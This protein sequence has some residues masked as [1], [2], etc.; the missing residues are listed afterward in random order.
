MAKKGDVFKCVSASSVH[1]VIIL[2][3]GKGRYIENSK[4]YPIVYDYNLPE[5]EICQEINI[6][7]ESVIRD[8]KLQAKKYPQEMIIRRF[9]VS[10]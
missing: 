5:K 7:I 9:I 1:S 2:F 3:S 6:L 10:C 4:I 8:S